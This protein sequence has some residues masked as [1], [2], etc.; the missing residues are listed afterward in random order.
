MHG[1]DYSEAAI[2]LSLKIAEEE[3]ICDQVAFSRRDI[4]EPPIKGDI[5]TFDIIL[6]K[7]TFDAISLAPAEA[8]DFEKRDKEKANLYVKYMAQLLVSGG[9]L[10]ITSCNW[11]EQELISL[12]KNGN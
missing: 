5:G 10:L 7:G 3:N 2:K 12:F 11:T 8:G 9:T 4:L 1:W 6:D